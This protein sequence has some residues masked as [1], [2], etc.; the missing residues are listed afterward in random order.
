MRR[1]EC[2]RRILVV[3]AVLIA[4]T[5]GARRVE[6]QTQRRSGRNDPRVGAA[7]A[8]PSSRPPATA[9][10]PTQRDPVRP[11]DDDTFRPTVIV[12]R[13]HSQ[14]TGT[15]IASEAGQSLVLTAAHVLR[16][17]GPISVELHRYNIGLEKTTG[18]AWPLVAA[19]EEAASDPAADIA[20][21]RFREHSPV[22]FVAR[23]YDGDPE[24]IPPESLA[25]SL[26]VDLGARLSSWNT[27]IVKS[28]RLQ[29]EGEG[30]GR[31]FL[32]TLKIPEHGR[33]GGGLYLEGGRLVGVCVGHAELVEGRRMGIFSSI[34]NIRRLIRE[35]KLDALVDRSQSRLAAPPAQEGEDKRPP[36]DPA[37]ATALNGRQ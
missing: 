4:G 11:G 29:M 2:V 15:I 28:T 1:T 27:K 33:S 21:L 13:G 18:G 31:P 22:P 37:G 9:A 5:A 17:E 7:R 10:E 6:A 35:N 32:I 14:G 26:G 20:L 34:E 19:A 3:A 30:W 36:T 23:L 25:T 8:T 16:D 12:R 24:R